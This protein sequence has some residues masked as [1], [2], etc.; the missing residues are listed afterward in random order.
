MQKLHHDLEERHPWYMAYHKI[1]YIS[2]LNFAF[3]IGFA[4]LSASI[5]GQQVNPTNQLAAVGSLLQDSAQSAQTDPEKYVPGQILV[6]FRTG[7]TRAAHDKTLK[8]AGASVKSSLSQIHVEVLS[9]PVGAEKRVRDALAHNPRVQFAELDGL[10]EPSLMPNDPYVNQMWALGKISAFN[11]WDISKGSGV[12]IAILDSGIDGGHQDLAANMLP[13]YNFMLNSSNTL[14]DGACHHGT[15]VAGS[16]AAVGNNATGTIGIAWQSKILPVVIAGPD[17]TG[18]GCW[19]SWS[20]LASGI[21]YAVDHGAKVINISYGGSSSGSSLLSAETYA[22][23]KGAVLVA[24][25]GNDALNGNPIRYPASDPHVVSAAATDYN[26]VA[27]SFSE[28]NQYVDLA[29]PGANVYDVDERGSSGYTPG[30]YATMSGTSFSAPTIAGL[31]ALVWSVNPSLTNQQVIDLMQKNADDLGDAGYDIHYGWGRIN[32]NR[33][34]AA[35]AGQTPVADTTAPSVVMPSIGTYAKGG[36]DITPTYSDDT[37]VAKIELWKD[38]S[39]YAT[40]PVG[41]F[42]FYWDTTLEVNGNHAIQLKAYD[43]AGNAGASVVK[44]VAVDNG[45][46]SATITSPASGASVAGPVTIGGTAA[47]ATSGVGSISLYVDGARVCSTFTSSPFTCQWNSVSSIDGSHTIKSEVYDKAGNIASTT[48]SIK[49][50]NNST[51]DTVPPSVSVTSPQNGA[52]VSKTVPISFTLSDNSGTVA[53]AELFKD[54]QLLSTLSSITSTSSNVFQWDTS[55]EANGSHALEVRAYDAA[56]NAGT[57]ATVTVTVDNTVPDIAKPTT[58]ISAPMGGSTLTGTIIVAAS[59]SD[60]VAVSKV[61]LFEDGALVSSDTTAPYAWSWDT[62]LDVNGTH[63]LQSKAY[64]AAGNMGSSAQISVVVSNAI[65][66][67]NAPPTVN[68][69]SPTNG[70]KIK[71][72]GNT[73]ISVTASDTDGIA[74]IVITIDGA[75]VKTCTNATSCSYAWSNKTMTSGSHTILATAVDKSSTAN[76]ASTSI[77]VTK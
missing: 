65:A 63:V 33:T 43:A 15:P 39:L 6:E 19:A 45:I 49:T 32:L 30:D 13:G 74:S 68:I 38:N 27:A 12:T 5:V 8:E 9:V 7:V 2:L 35:A 4:Y 10:V 22:W 11:G 73:S 31:A 66:S 3:F 56:N 57:S 55:K 26:D 54:G 76:S 28:Y 61:D 75:K 67:T 42:S 24:S 16:A 36:V 51:L 59:A 62:T 44:T 37:G 48:V 64:D 58:V 23:N 29:A 14:P 69:I 41:P 77:T 50:I 20:N 72:N 1:P 40:D 60:N 53:R 70:A 25:A 52:I 34:L 18:T 47:D 21:T 46:P 17:S 71:T